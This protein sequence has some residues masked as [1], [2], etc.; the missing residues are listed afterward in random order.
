MR[1]QHRV[2]LS[3]GCNQFILKSLHTCAY[4]TGPHSA[5]VH[6]SPRVG[7]TTPSGVNEH[8]SKNLRAGRPGR[9]SKRHKFGFGAVEVSEWALSDD[10][11]LVETRGP[12]ASEK[13]YGSECVRRTIEIR[14]DSVI[15]VAESCKECDR[16]AVSAEQKIVVH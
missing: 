8:A 12:T 16:R 10:E 9:S 11:G 13:W 5:A 15:G 3:P 14:R 4:M 1:G 7:E 2:S 6:S